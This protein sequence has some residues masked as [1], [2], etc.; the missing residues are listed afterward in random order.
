MAKGKSNEAVGC[1]FI[2]HIKVTGYKLQ[3][4]GYKRQLKLKNQYLKPETKT[5]I[6]KSLKLANDFI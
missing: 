6:I 3:V 4:T 5:S 1:Y 2:I